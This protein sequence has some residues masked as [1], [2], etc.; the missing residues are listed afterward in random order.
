MPAPVPR[1]RA[2][3]RGV[4]GENSTDTTPYVKKV[5]P[6]SPEA[7]RRLLGAVS[8][9]ILFSHLDESQMDEVVDA[10]F[11]VEKGA[12]D[13]VIVQGEEGDNFYIVDSGELDIF[14]QKGD[15][16]PMKVF[17][18]KAGNS[19]GE[20]ALMYNC[21]RAATVVSNG[22]SELWGLDRV[23]FQHIL[24]ATGS[25]RRD[26]YEGFLSSIPLPSVSIFFHN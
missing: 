8:N 22:S 16:A 12:G 5:H 3:R 21:P 1:A 4:S 2:R 18:A 20:L 25:S 14:V 6:K 9:N 23:T 11:G 19:F 10:F 13:K 15:A 17:T 7:R 26:Q 24:K